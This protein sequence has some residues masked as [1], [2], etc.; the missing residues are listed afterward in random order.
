MTKNSETEQITKIFSILGRREALNLLANSNLSDREQKLLA[1]RMVRGMTLDEC[2][3]YFNMYRNSIAKWQTKVC[4]KLYTWLEARHTATSLLH[5]INLDS[6]TYHLSDKI[7]T[8]L[9]KDA[10]NLE[11]AMEPELNS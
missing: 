11:R 1:L 9:K 10:L 4:K 5:S 8:T 6:I 3:D 7:E 2:S